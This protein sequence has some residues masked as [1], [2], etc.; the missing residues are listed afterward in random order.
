MDVASAASLAEATKAAA[1]RAEA[2]FEALRSELATALGVEAE[3]IWPPAVELLQDEQTARE[4][5][6]Q[7]LS[8]LADQKIRRTSAV[9]IDPAHVRDEEE[10]E[11]S[12]GELAR[13]KQRIAN[14][15]SE[16]E[17]KREH[18]KLLESER[19]ERWSKVR[20]AKHPVCPYD[21]TRLDVDKVSF[22]CPLPRLPDPVAAQRIAEETNAARERV[23]T[24]LAEDEKNLTGLSGERASLNA[25]VG[26][27]RRRIQAHELAVAEATRASQDAWATKGLVRRLFDLRA[28]SDHALR[29]EVEAE[30]ALR[31]LQGRQVA[32]LAAFSTRQLQHWF[33]FLVQRVVAPE[34]TGSIV[35]DGNGL[36]PKIHWRGTRRSVALNSLQ[37][38]LFDLAAMLC[39]VEGHSHAPAFLVH[40][41]PREGDLDPW[42]YS[43]LF[44]ALYE[45]EPNEAT[46]PFQYIVTT[47]TDPPEGR[48]RAR[49]RLEINADEEQ[50][51]LFQVDL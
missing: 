18:A 8:A 51:R 26:A 41:S 4:K 34:A 48:V 2:R 43:R 45:L 39:A 46:A 11:L 10:L 32:G 6:L 19:F 37:I 40:D 14:L 25:K 3:R 5:H 20:E 33:D 38:V 47:T 23:L 9:S 49:V 30:E 17:R 42:T 21:G 1:R 13:V 27:L 44:E 31:G 28:A 36:H 16:V 35:L 15:E 7:G 24:E 12:E 29:A 50:N 22:V